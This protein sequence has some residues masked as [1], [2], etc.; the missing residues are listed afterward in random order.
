MDKNATVH[1]PVRLI[2]TT[3]DANFRGSFAKVAVPNPWELAP[4]D[5]PT[6]ISSLTPILVKKVSPNEAPN[7]PVM[8]TDKA[9]REGSAPV[10]LAPA[11]ASGLVMHLVKVDK[12]IEIGVICK[13]LA[14]AAEL[15]NPNI[16]D[17]QVERAILGA[18]FARVDL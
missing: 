17:I 10:I 15:N 2:L 18:L 14:I 5:K 3:A 7:T 11:R 1:S 4:I 9:A 6:D 8:T 12:A 13:N 16:A